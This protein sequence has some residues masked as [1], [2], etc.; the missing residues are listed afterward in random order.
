[1]TPSGE[2]TSTGLKTLGQSAQV[3]ESLHLLTGRSGP[4]ARLF[5]TSQTLLLSQRKKICLQ[6]A[7]QVRKHLQQTF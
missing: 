6:E 5:N 3:T 1:M 4:T 7:K 2:G